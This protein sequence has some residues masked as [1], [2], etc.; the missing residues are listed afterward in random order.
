MWAGETLHVDT[1]TLQEDGEHVWGW[2][3]ALRKHQ[4]SPLSLK[5]AGM[6]GCRRVGSTAHTRLLLHR[7]A[8]GGRREAAPTWLLSKEA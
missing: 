3:V 7:L 1:W 2:F 5:G 8:L 6:W 4:G